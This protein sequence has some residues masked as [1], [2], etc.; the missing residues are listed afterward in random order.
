MNVA[1]STAASTPAQNRFPGFPLAALGFL[2]DLAAN[3]RRDWLVQH[4]SEL[5]A[6]LLDP[7]RALVRELAPQLHRFSP[8]LRA[9]PHVGGSILRLHRDARFAGRAHFKEHL[10]LWFWEGEGPSRLH[11]GFFI[12]L[13]PL[14]LAVGCGIRNLPAERLA[15]YRQ[16][17]DE[18]STGIE[19]VRVLHRLSRTGWTLNGP[20]SREVPTPYSPG[21]ERADLLRRT[22]LWVEC[23]TEP[24]DELY[25]PDLIL[26]LRRRFRALLPL[27]RWLRGIA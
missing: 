9:E 3:N 12:R 20:R 13:A 25:R 11:P 6:F 23:R 2:T 15:S 24:P 26:L 16:A 19:L 5:E 10:E 27:H 21:H 22:G 14:C 1:S 17:V 4:R 7:S 8:G 18:P